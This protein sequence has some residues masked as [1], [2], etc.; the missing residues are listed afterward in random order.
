MKT[1]FASVAKKKT[2]SD[3]SDPCTEVYPSPSQYRHP[4]IA[5]PSPTHPQPSSTVTDRPDHPQPSLTVPTH[6]QPILTVPNRILSF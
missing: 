1:S 6:P 3:F 5:L 2:Y 4:T